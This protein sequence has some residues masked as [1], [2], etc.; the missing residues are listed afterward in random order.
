MNKNGLPTLL[1][2]V[3]GG[4]YLQREAAIAAAITQIAASAN[5][6]SNAVIL[7]GLPDGN[8]ILQADSSLH[9]QRIAPG[10]IC[11]IG[12]LVLRVT[13]NRILK[14]PP[15][16]LYLGIANASHLDQLIDFLQQAPYRE[17]LKLEHIHR[18]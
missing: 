17:L 9:I 4:S 10:C 18:G 12:N 2:I 6:A 1:T 16:R 11:C 8:Q 5:T 13:L 3:S 15:T 14:Q 7:E